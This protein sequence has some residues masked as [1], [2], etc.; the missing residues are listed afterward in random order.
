MSG[1]RSPKLIRAL[2]TECEDKKFTECV[3]KAKVLEQVTQDV[4]DINSSDKIHFQN[5][6]QLPSTHVRKG[7]KP[8][9]YEKRSAS[10]K[11]VSPS[12]K[13]IRCGTTGRHLA[14][15]CFALNITCRSCNK[16]GHLSKVCKSSK[17]SKNKYKSHV[18]KPDYEPEEVDV[19]NFI[20]MKQVRKNSPPKYNVAE[21][22]NFYMP[23]PSRPATT[24][25]SLSACN[26][27][28]LLTD[29]IDAAEKQPSYADMLKED[30]PCAEIKSIRRRC[31][32]ASQNKSDNSFLGQRSRSVE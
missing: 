17:E 25:G 22:D 1:L 14:H 27:F 2:I 10:S 31:R 18:I 15:E 3:E 19:T 6:I 11:T 23:T 8:K 26:S 20:Q 29:E 16:V 9:P 12:Y 24:T 32:L 21:L 30:P 5:K 4:D 13:C 28:E 7:P